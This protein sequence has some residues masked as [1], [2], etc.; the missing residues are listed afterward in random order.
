MN[1]SGGLVGSYSQ[2]G[3][4]IIIVDDAGNELTGVIT[5]NLQIF[6]ATPAD[7]KIG[8]T[9]ASDEGIQV[10]EDTKTCRVRHGAQLILPGKTFSIP[11]K[12]YDGYDYTNFQ[13]IVSLFNTSI[14]DSSETNR[15]V[16]Y[17]AVYNVNSNIKIA[18]IEK[19]VEDK[20]IDLNLTNDTDDVYII[21]FNT[22]REE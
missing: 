20:S 7:V 9:F 21:H 13:A 16:L 17:D 6:D 18:D 3:K 14:V 19:N 5:E 8:K 4:T 2:L 12:E 1:I 10:G 22:Y 11:I 15:V